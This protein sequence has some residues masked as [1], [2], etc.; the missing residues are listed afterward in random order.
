MP[1]RFDLEAL[2]KEH[3]CSVYFETGLYDPRLDVSIRQANDCSFDKIYSIEIRE[4]WVGFGKEVF[5][6]EILAGRIH[7]ILDDSVNLQKY[8]KEDI[9]KENKT[10]FFLD[11]H[12]DNNNIHNY[13]KKCPLLEELEAIKSMD[14]KDHVILVDD[15][16]YLREPFPWWEDSYGNIHF[17]EHIQ[18]K[19]LEI[20]E[21][22]KFLTL[23]G[24][25]ED[26]IL[27]AYI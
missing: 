7:L 1:I 22:Y 20:N 8:L 27:L 16:Q 19:I 13:Q 17:L 11:A 14:R 21:N 5:Q 10:M 23:P 4:D 25:L 2:R 24:V 26:D 18:R 3:D 15:L 12:V 9:F 6:Q